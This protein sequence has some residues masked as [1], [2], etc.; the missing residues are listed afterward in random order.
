MFDNRIARLGRHL[1]AI[2]GF[3]CVVAGSLS[4]SYEAFCEAPDPY[5]AARQ[6]MVDRQLKARDITDSKVLE[7]ITLSPSGK[8]RPSLSRT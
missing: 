5:A 4:F 3:L 8:V 1:G 7:V 2:L 6:R